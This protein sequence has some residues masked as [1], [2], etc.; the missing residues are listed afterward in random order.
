MFKHFDKLLFTSFLFATFGAIA[1]QNTPIQNI[2]LGPRPFF[3]VSQKWS[4]R[5]L[6]YFPHL[7][8]VRASI[9]H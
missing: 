8:I 5:S 1:E 6:D 3:L 7:R 4:A 2:Q 9:F